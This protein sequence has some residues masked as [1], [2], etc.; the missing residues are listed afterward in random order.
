MRVQHG[1]MAHT[2]IYT[3]HTYIHTHMTLLHNIYYTPQACHIALYRHIFCA[4]AMR[5]QRDVR[6]TSL[7]M[8]VFY[9]VKGENP[10]RLLFCWGLHM[11]CGNSSRV[12]SSPAATQSLVSQESRQN[13]CLSTT[14][15]DI[16]QHDQ[17]R[18]RYHQTD[19]KIHLGGYAND[20]LQPL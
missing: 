12:M 6:T 15:R 2:R 17:H 7:D 14:W 10:L 5:V 9:S 3:T 19:R 8:C 11:R 18:E 13:N 20:L 1:S 16:S 4:S